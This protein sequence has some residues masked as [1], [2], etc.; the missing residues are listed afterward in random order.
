M[1][2]R[3]IVDPKNTL[4]PV[5]LDITGSH[6][7]EVSELSFD[8]DNVDIYSADNKVGDCNLVSERRGKSR[9]A[10]FDGIEIDQESRGRG[11]GLAT[12][13][14]AIEL[15]YQRGYDFETQNWELTA[16]SKKVWEH[17]AR[18]GVAEVI[19][20]FEPSRRHGQ[21]DRFVGRYRVPILR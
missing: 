19:F 17:L 16:H 14:L 7:S 5:R 15:S 2:I 13:I 9:I 18:V 4:P 12:Y 10:H 11:V 6:T 20:P 3:N 8:Y 21:A 1:S